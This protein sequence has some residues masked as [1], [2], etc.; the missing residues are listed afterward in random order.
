MER[1]LRGNLEHCFG[2]SADVDSSRC[3]SRCKMS[4]QALVCV[5]KCCTELET[6]RFDFDELNDLQSGVKI[7]AFDAPISSSTKNTSLKTLDI[8]SNFWS[9]RSH[10]LY[11]LRLISQFFRLFP[12]LSSFSL[13]QRQF[14]KPLQPPNPLLVNV[15]TTA[16]I[17]LIHDAFLDS[18][19]RDIALDFLCHPGLEWNS[20]ASLEELT[21][22][23]AQI[24][25]RRN[26]KILPLNVQFSCFEFLQNLRNY[27]R[28]R[29]DRG[30]IVA[31]EIHFETVQVEENRVSYQRRLQLR[32][33]A[34]QLH[35]ICLEEAKFLQTRPVHVES[36]RYPS[37]EHRLVLLD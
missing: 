31:F 30:T 37:L 9:F 35:F 25:Q 4:A 34:R 16:Y 19:M 8:R 20:L 29:S 10:N 21:K 7:D 3:G 18:R 28:Y 5:I 17:Q 27:H 6:L 24:H 36:C 13:L 2:K 26:R 32:Q 23:V 33:I 11:W 15:E 1:I 14:I 22:C 12:C